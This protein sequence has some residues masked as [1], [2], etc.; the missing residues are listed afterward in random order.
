MAGLGL[1]S[2]P[3]SRVD[4]VP[5]SIELYNGRAPSQ[6]PALAH[7]AFGTSA[8]GAVA[9][10]GLSPIGQDEAHEIW[11]PAA[12]QWSGDHGRITWRADS[13][14]LFG[15]VIVPLD[16]DIEQTTSDLYHE[17]FDC[18]AAQGFPHLLRVWHYLPQINHGQ[19]S[20]EQYQQ[21]CLGRA[22]A[23]DAWFDS[24]THLPAGTAIG[25]RAGNELQIYFLATRQPVQQIENPRQV[26][27]F[28]YPR[29]Y[30]PR[31]PQFSRAVVW[32]HGTGTTLLVSGTAS[33]VGHQS[34]HPGDLDG[35]LQE[36]WRN[37]ESL[38]TT[39]GA[40]QVLAL[41]VY[42]RHAE[43]YQQVRRFVADAVAASTPVLYLHADICREELLV[44][45]EGV[46]ALPQGSP[47]RAGAVTAGGDRVC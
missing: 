46:Y 20:H 43:H 37:L 30:G 14:T 4:S 28:Q 13:N 9:H 25:T 8:S 32:S 36:T 17:I 22:R 44:E 34:M 3:V 38:R 33:I 41:R 6:A 39:A 2:R 10:P 19:G 27:A 45:I 7:M 31:E 12:P 11:R 42:I 21:F 15:S 5:L 18:I 26:S 35:Q 29:Q 16:D 1:M 40:E 23:F 47:G 24:T